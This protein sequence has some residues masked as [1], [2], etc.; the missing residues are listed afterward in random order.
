MFWRLK[1][2]RHVATHY[3][4]LATNFLAAAIVRYWL[5]VSRPIR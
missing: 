3:D 4:K 2:F 1:D 5:R